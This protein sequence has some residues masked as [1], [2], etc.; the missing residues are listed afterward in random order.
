MLANNFNTMALT[1]PPNDQ[2]YMDSGASS[3]MVSNSDIL[4]HVHSYNFST[5]SNIIVGNGSSLSV[6]AVGSTSF[7]LPPHHYTYIMFLFL[8]TLLKTL[9]LFAVS[10]LII[11]VLLNLILLVLL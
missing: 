5:P 8:H 2:W 10:L 4:T 7:P 9:F 6:T 1:P 11:I 3:H